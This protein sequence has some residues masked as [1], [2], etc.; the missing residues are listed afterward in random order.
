MTDLEDFAEPIKTARLAVQSLPQ[1][2]QGPAFSV[3]LERLLGHEGSAPQSSPLVSSAIPGP[4]SASSTSM[5]LPHVVKERG[6]RRQRVAWALV[7]L[8]NRSESAT[9]DAVMRVIKDEMGATPP[10]AA[11]VS[12]ELKE[13]TPRFATRTKVGHAYAYTPRA[14]IGDVFDGLEDE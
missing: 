5:P 11:H 4:V 1:H 3:I 8:A 6:S 14:S 7:T 12:T 10:S 2:L 13:M 9:P